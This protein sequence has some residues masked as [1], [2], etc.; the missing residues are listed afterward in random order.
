M[1][2]VEGRGDDTGVCFE[3]SLGKMIDGWM[4]QEKDDARRGHDNNG[5]EENR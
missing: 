5:T 4:G 1:G 3:I 2:G